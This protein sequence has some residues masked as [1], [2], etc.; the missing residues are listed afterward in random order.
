MIYLADTLNTK[1]FVRYASEGIVAVDPQN[2][3]QIGVAAPD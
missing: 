2:V 1:H 3:G